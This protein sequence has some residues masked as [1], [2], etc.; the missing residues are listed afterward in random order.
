[1]RSHSIWIAV[2]SV[3]LALAAVPVYVWL[4]D[5]PVLRSSGLPAFFLMAL[6]TGMAIF[7]ARKNRR[8]W[9]KAVAGF[10]AAI[11]AL[12]AW[13]FFVGAKVPE[14][15]AVT[16]CLSQAPQFTLPDHTGQQVSL[17]DAL[18]TGPVLLVFYRGHW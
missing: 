3:F 16:T 6:G 2:A 17:G 13:F 10:N 5:V 9:T 12:F 15:A 14:A 8:I 18:S 11:L 4:A 7:A 1:M